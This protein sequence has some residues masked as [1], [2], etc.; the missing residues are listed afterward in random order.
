[1]RTLVLV[2]GAALAGC[3][4]GGAVTDKGSAEAE[5]VTNA[6]ASTDENAAIANAQEPAAEGEPTTGHPCGI[7]DG[8]TVTA[9]PMR[10]IGTEPFWN[11]RTDGRCV[12]YSTPEDQA[13]T[14]VWAKAETG[15]GRSVWTGA[16]NGKPFVLTIRPS[17]SCS[18]GMSDKVYAYEAE[19]N[20]GG[21]LRQGCAEKA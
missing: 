19:L 17:K 5:A 6:V 16:L 8:R 12:T 7:Q 20:V 3:G 15:G 13:G 11:A 21:E 14:R 4:Q 2:L 9:Q 10:A 18:D 1:M